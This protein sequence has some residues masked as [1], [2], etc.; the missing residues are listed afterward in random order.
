MFPCRPSIPVLP[1]PHPHPH[2]PPP[3]ALQV[4]VGASKS[5]FSSAV[6]ASGRIAVAGTVKAGNPFLTRVGTFDVDLALDVRGERANLE[7][8]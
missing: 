7:L 8:V 4:A 6:D 3:P 1:S 5:K 2:S